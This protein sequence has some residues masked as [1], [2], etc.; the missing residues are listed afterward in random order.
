MQFHNQYNLRSHNGSLVA[1]GD[2]GSSLGQGSLTNDSSDGSPAYW[3]D[4]AGLLHEWLR[5]RVPRMLGGGA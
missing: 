3:G 5:Q 1:N 4:A 2:D